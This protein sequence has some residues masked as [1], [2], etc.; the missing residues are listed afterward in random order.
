MQ[1][2]EE[3]AKDSAAIDDYS[4]PLDWEL[5][6]LENKV[7]LYSQVKGNKYWL[8]LRRWVLIK[9]RVCKIS[10]TFYF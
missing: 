2:E 3:D 5:F 6:P 7:C 1:I 4:L 9:W 10:L 8:F